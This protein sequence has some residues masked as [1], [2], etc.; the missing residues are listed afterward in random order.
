MPVSEAT[1]STSPRSRSCS[2]G[3]GWPSSSSPSVGIWTWPS[4]PAIPAAPR[5]HLAGLDDAAAEPG[6]DDR[7]DRRRVATASAPKC[8]WWA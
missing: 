1:L 3:T 6:A 8:T 7:R 2:C 5:D 4:S